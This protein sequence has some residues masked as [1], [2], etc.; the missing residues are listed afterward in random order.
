M[1]NVRIFMSF[2][3]DNDADLHDLLLEQSR[4]QSSGF[5]ISA[6]SDGATMTDHW[7]ER[8][9][10]QIS[11]ADEVIV[12]CGE[13]TGSSVRV[14]AE[15]RI[16][17][18]EKKPYFLL[19]GRRDRMCTKPVGSKRDD[20]MYSWTWQILQDQIVTTLRNAQPRE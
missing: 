1:A 9:R 8:V 12:I 5:E 10:R 2:D 7:D 16:A 13:H 14:S 15:L 4:K 18:E 3:P 19:W 6:R 20:S 17:Q 11:Q